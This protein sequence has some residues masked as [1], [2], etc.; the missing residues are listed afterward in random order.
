MAKKKTNPAEVAGGD[1]ASPS[2]MDAMPDA[3]PAAATTTETKSAGDEPVSPWFSKLFDRRPDLLDSRKNDEIF[4][5][6]LQEHP[7]Y[8]EV[9]HNIKNIL[10]NVKSQKRREKEGGRKGKGKGKRKARA[11]VQAAP[12]N[13]AAPKVVKTSVRGLEKLEEM[14]DHCL[15]LARGEAPEELEAVI[16]HLRKARNQVVHKM[17]L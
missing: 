1:G 5:I 15:S 16:H 6:W 3:G 17:G 8:K 14:I 12:S 11:K 13:G 4:T 9:P 7:T 2:A 10:S